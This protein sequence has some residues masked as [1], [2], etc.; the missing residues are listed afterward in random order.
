MSKKGLKVLKYIL[1]AGL[2][3]LL[4]YLALR[5]MDWHI[6]LNALYDTKWLWVAASLAFA[7]AALVFRPERW[8]LLMIP[9]NSEIK[10]KDLW[11]ACN[12]GNLLS[13]VLPWVSFLIR[14]GAV[15]DKKTPYDKTVGTILME[16][17]WDMMMVFI[18]IVLAIVLNTGEIA[19]WFIDNIALKIAGRWKIAP[20]LVGAVGVLALA[21]YVI[22]KLKDRSK[23]AGKL[24]GWIAGIFDGFKTFAQTPRKIPFVLLS[25]SIWVSYFM[26]CFCVFKAVPSLSHLGISDALFISVVGNL[27]SLLPVPGG[28]GA[29]H[30]FV[31]TALSALYGVSWEIGIL[32]ASLTHETRSLMLVALGAISLISSQKRIKIE[33]SRE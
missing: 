32:F 30:Y 13:V 7:L 1:A 33:D 21:I 28:F 24:A 17:A 9:I 12:I 22:F 5:K 23:L 19:N 3:A 8:R 25:A 14:C 6:F 16:R 20:I 11:D 27:S 31:A 29:Y 4:V 15:T 26:M 18:L 10:R 2:A